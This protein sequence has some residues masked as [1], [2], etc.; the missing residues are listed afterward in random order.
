MNFK[1]LIL[2]VFILTSCSVQE[3]P[4]NRSYIPIDFEQAIDREIKLESIADSIK[5]TFLEYDKKNIVGKIKKF[6]ITRKY[7]LVVDQQEKLFVFKRNGELLSTIHNRGKGPSEYV[8]IEDFSVD[9]NEEHI[10]ILASTNGKVLKY[11]TNGLYEN[12]YS[13]D[14]THA[15]H[16][17][18]LL[19]GNYCIYQSAR[20]SKEHLNLFITDA[21][22]TVTHSFKDPNGI[23]LRKL[24]YLLDVHWYKHNNNIY[25]KEVL[26]DTVFGINYLHESGIFLCV[27]HR[28][29]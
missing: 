2:S 7:I 29:N 21:N 23:H 14:H 5:F 4:N 15:A 3:P 20:F 19:N 12:E 26:G 27:D 22:F 11:T 10:F 9:P 6:K 24:P 13:I 1:F 28:Y 17:S 16:L 18:G 25:Y 8:S